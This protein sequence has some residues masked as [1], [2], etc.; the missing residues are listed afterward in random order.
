MR[1]I[2]EVTDPARG[3]RTAKATSSRPTLLPPPRATHPGA[4][5]N[6]SL[7]IL[8]EMDGQVDEQV[9]EAHE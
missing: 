3:S 9:Q 8:G 6:A 1:L 4:F 7:S 5:T 2:P